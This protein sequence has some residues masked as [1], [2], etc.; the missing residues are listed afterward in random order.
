MYYF[1]YDIIFFAIGGFWVTYYCYFNAGG[2]P[3]V[4]EKFYLGAS[5]QWI[6]IGDYGYKLI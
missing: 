5:A 6:E 3:E 4:V 2:R 1:V